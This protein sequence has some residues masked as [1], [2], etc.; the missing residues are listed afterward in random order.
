MAFH[1]GRRSRLLPI[2]AL[3]TAICVV[4]AL[5]LVRYRS[6]YC[7]SL[8]YW[9][10]YW[11]SQLYC[12]S[13]VCA[14]I[15]L[16]HSPKFFPNDYTAVYHDAIYARFVSWRV[17]GWAGPLL[18]ASFPLGACVARICQPRTSRLGVDAT[19]SDRNVLQC[20]IA[21]PDTALDIAAADIRNRGVAA[22]WG[23]RAIGC[24]R[25]WASS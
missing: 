2:V 25:S 9:Q 8:P 13:L 17:I 4:L 6:G 24:I 7:T 16:R 5:F 3:G 10:R 12:D 19:G 11:S 20:G 23:I 15:I 21:P 14:G 1:H 22:L 18:V